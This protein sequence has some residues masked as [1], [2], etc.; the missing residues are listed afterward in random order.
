MKMVKSLLL[1]SAAGLVAVAAAQAADLPVKAAPVEYVKVCSLYGAGYYYMPGTDICMKIGGYIRFQT[2]FGSANGSNP[3]VRDS[4]ASTVTNASGYG[5][6]TRGVLTVDTRQQTAYGTLR[7]YFLIGH[8]ATNSNATGIFATRA[9]IQWAGFTFGRATSFFDHFPSSSRAYFSGNIHSPNTGD[10]GWN[11]AAYTAQFG[12][13]FSATISLEEPRNPPNVTE[14]TAAGFPDGGFAQSRQR[15]GGLRN[16]PDIVANL[17]LDQA[18]G[19]AMI[20]GALHDASAVY[21]GGAFNGLASP[22]PGDRMGWA[23]TAATQINLPMINPGSVF[24][25]QFTYTR[26]AVGYASHAALSTGVNSFDGSTWSYGL[27]TDGVF[28]NPATIA[29]NVSGGIE[30]TTAWSLALAYDHVWRPGLKTSLYGSYLDVSFG[31]NATAL[32]CASAFNTPVGAALP[33]GAACSP[34]WSMWNIGSRTEWAPVR[35]L[36]L[37]VDVVYNRI[38]GAEFHNAAGGISSGPVGWAGGT[39][40]SFGNRDS[41]VGMFRIQRSYHP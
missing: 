28:A 27:F 20:G 6:R 19:S 13:G 10:A 1:G 32:Q 29:G 41:V 9:F 16:Y 34:N 38:E 25:A 23:L 21:Y 35:G 12:N 7:T 39:A 30:L 15:Y 14:I 2:T 18:W 22:G 3:A 24:N 5:Y 26:G 37:G 36:T 8:Q 17:R 40:T 31:G 33:A 11:V 4:R